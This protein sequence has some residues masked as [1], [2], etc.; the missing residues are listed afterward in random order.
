M[1]QVEDK[2]SDRH[3][4]AFTVRLPEAEYEALRTFAVYTD[5]TMSEVLLRSLREFLAAEGRERD[6]DEMLRTAQDRLRRTMRQF[7]C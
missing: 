2:D 4:R 7:K 1:G 3:T 5:A 6:I